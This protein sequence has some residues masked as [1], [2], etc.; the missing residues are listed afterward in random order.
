MESDDFRLKRFMHYY[1]VNLVN[2]SKRC[3]LRREY[4]FFTD[5][6]NA[7]SVQDARDFYYRDHK[8][9][10]YFQSEPYERLCVVEL[11]ESSL[12][13]LSRTHERMFKDVGVSTEEY[14]KTLIQKEWAEH[15]LRSKYPAVQAAWEHYSLMLHLASDGK[16]PS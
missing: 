8:D 11:P 12:N 10:M 15:D 6:T 2:D 7:N 9:Q 3:L 13:H 16:E 5:P 14:A 4:K 1:N